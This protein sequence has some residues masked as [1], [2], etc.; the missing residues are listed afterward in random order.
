MARAIKKTKYTKYK[1]FKNDSDAKKYLEKLQSDNPELK[2]SIKKRTFPN[3]L[4]TRF[5]V[6]SVA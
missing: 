6:R 3:K 1:T 4:K 5:T 2:F